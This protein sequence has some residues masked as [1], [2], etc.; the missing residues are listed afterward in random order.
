MTKIGRKAVLGFSLVTA[1]VL[2]GCTSDATRPTEGPVDVSL[3][4][5]KEHSYAVEARIAHRL[6]GFSDDRFQPSDGGSTLGCSGGGLTWASSA[7]LTV[8]DDPDFAEIERVVR[9]EF[10]DDEA[11]RVE[12]S[13]TS[14][15]DP[16][17]LVLGRHGEDHSVEMYMG[18]LKIYSF[19][20]C[21]I[22]DPE[23]DGWQWEL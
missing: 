8:D 6:P 7:L 22:H 16:R 17:L 18:Y 4:E 19:S 9:D 2:G 10:A 13:E 21:F 14:G 3:V 5:V 12:M 11:F 1:M 15:G 23:R 20:P